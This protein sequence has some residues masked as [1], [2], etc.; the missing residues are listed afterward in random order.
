MSKRKA[1]QRKKATTA[2]AARGKRR[3]VA[4]LAILLSLGLAGGIFAQW[5]ATSVKTGMNAMLLPPTPAVPSP[6]SPSKEYI[7]AGGRLLATEEPTAS[8]TPSPSPS[9]SPTPGNEVVWVEDQVPAG[10]MTGANGETWDWVSSPLNPYS[11]TL[12]HRSPNASGHHNHFFYSATQTLTVNA[13]EKLFTYVYI[14]PINVP[15]ELMLQWH[16]GTNWYNF[17]WGADQLTGVGARTSMGAIPATGQ[18]VRLDVSAS[19]LGITIGSKTFSGM[20]FNLYG[21]QAT[22][23]RAGKVNNDVVWFD[24]QLP[25]GAVGGGNEAWSWVSSSPAPY[26][27]TLAH[28]SANVAN[29]FHNHYFTGATQTLAVG[30]TDKLYA[31]IYINPNSVPSEV[32]LQWTDG[33][34]WYNASWGSNQISPSGNPPVNMGAVPATGQWVRL[35]VPA[36]SIGAGGKTLTGMAFNLWGGQATWDRAGKTT[37]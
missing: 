7:Y 8:P 5:R 36:S 10:A 33:N 31:Y 28:Q 1:R 26:S 23:D 12:A 6:G 13:G 19:L 9:P 22:W 16:D 24:D 30:T 2:V 34:N 14:D 32:L 11:G 17:Y 25:T 4:I 15:S 20:A 37:P 35:E 21:G 18:W 3:V 29:A 27:G